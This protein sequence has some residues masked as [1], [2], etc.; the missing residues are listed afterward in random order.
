MGRRNRYY[1]PGIPPNSSKP[2]LNFT[3]PRYL[4]WVISHSRIGTG[5]SRESSPSPP[6]ETRRK[7]GFLCDNRQS[8]ILMKSPVLSPRR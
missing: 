2:V 6:E 3:V 8:H 4:V 5:L 7:P 1:V